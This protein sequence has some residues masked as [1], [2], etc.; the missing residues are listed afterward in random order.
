MAT[1]DTQTESVDV[2]P[3]EPESAAA[4]LPA[5]QTLIVSYCLNAHIM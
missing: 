3:A 1:S 2:T 4:A 5:E